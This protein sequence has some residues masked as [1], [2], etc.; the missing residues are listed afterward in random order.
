MRHI[1]TYAARDEGNPL[2][3]ESP[4]GKLVIAKAF[5]FVIARSA[6]TW[7]SSAFHAERSDT[8]LFCHRGV[9]FVTAGTFTPPDALP[10]PTDGR[11]V[12]MA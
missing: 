8:G 11:G 5:P 6:A 10:L 1:D 9:S 4:L 3:G 2:G 7:Q 12:A